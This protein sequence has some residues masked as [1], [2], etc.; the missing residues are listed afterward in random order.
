ML[1]G[2]ANAEDGTNGGYNFVNIVYGSR[3]GRTTAT[4]SFSALSPISMP[5]SSHV[6]TKRLNPSL[7]RLNQRTICLTSR[8]PTIT[9]MSFPAQKRTAMPGW[10]RF[11]LLGLVIFVPNACSSLPIFAV[12]RSVPGTQR[13]FQSQGKH[14]HKPPTSHF[15]HFSLSCGN[16]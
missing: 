1:S 8:T 16:P 9:F 13:T 15:W 11:L 7:L 14:W 5:I 12:L 10:R 4:K 3:S 6:Y 2:R